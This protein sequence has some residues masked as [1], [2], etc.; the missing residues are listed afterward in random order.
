MRNDPYDVL[1]VDPAADAAII[2]AAYLALMREHHPDHRPGD[3]VAAELSRRVNAAY[4]ILGDETRRAAHDRRHDRRHDR[5]GA[6]A[7]E[8]AAGASVLRPPAYSDER[9]TFQRSFTAATVRYAL[10][11]FAIGTVLL[12]SLA[13]Q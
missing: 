2:R 10:V 7:A 6:P 1:G 9:R 11:L 13:A 3:S 4:G 5:P 12:L 8:P